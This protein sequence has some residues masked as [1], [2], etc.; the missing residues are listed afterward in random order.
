[1]PS[2]LQHCLSRAADPVDHIEPDRTLLAKALALATHLDYPVYDCLYLVLA[3]RE[4]ALL[5]SADSRLLELSKK[6]LP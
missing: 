4:V 5:L 6:V 1:M 3:R 2:G